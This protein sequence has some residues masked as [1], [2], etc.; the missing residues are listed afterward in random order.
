[1]TPLPCQGA[2]QK[3][4]RDNKT[5][6]WLLEGIKFICGPSGII[7]KWCHEGTQI[8]CPT[9]VMRLS[10]LSIHKDKL[11]LKIWGFVHFKATTPNV[12]CSLQKYKVSTCRVL[13][14][15]SK[16]RKL[17]IAQGFTLGVKGLTNSTT[18]KY[19]STAFPMNGH[20]LGFWNQSDSWIS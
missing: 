15:E 18:V 16:V 11:W 5:M 14:I 7:C 3:G 19:C 9:D 20:T 4:W 10:F 17:C 12:E 6:T 13:S 8:N 2:F 1:M